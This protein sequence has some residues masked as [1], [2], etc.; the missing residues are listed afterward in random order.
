MFAKK[1]FCRYD[2]T[3]NRDGPTGFRSLKVNKKKHVIVK[4]GWLL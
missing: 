2:S 4:N 1:K 3:I